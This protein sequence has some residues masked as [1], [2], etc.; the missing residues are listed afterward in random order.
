[1]LKELLLLC[2]QNSCVLFTD[3][4]YEQIDGVFMGS[5]LG[6]VFANIFMYE[7]EIKLLKSGRPKYHNFCNSL[8]CGYRYV[9]DIFCVFSY[10]LNT[11]VL[12]NVLNSLHINLK[13]TI[14]TK[15]VHT[16]HFLD[17]NIL[18]MIIIDLVLEPILNQPILA[19]IC[20]GIVSFLILTKLI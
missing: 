7:I 1:M 11:Q 14:E 2:T 17:V 13:F 6:H 15:T 4:L 8:Y 3:D 9:D 16:F 5:P 19:C 12:L 18:N 10:E 20:Y